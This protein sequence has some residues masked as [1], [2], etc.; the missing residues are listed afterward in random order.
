MTNISG[1]EITGVE[2]TFGIGYDD[3]NESAGSDFK[4]KQ[5]LSIYIY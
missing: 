4:S 3:D 1:Q 2:L 5:N